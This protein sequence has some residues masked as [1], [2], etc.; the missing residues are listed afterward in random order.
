MPPSKVSSFLFSF[1]ARILRLLG[2]WNRGNSQTTQLRQILEVDGSFNRYHRQLLRFRRDDG[3]SDDF[4]LVHSGIDF[5]DLTFFL[6]R[7]DLA[8][9]RSTKLPANRFQIFDPILSVF[10]ELE[11]PD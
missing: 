8:P 9:S 2:N 11:T 5:T 1:F 4:P 6:L 3:E 7:D 10:R